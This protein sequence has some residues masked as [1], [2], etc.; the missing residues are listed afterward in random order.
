MAAQWN[1]LI[2]IKAWLTLKN[3]DLPQTRAW[4]IERVS[5]WTSSVLVETSPLAVN[6]EMALST[7]LWLSSFDNQAIWSIIKDKYAR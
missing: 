4:L 1:F 2:H 3:G 6:T 5:S 7:E